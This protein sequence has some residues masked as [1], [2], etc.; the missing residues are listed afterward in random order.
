MHQTYALMQGGRIYTLVPI[1]RRDDPLFKC[2][3]R[4]WGFMDGQ[5]ISCFKTKKDF[6]TF[7]QAEPNDFPNGP[8]AAA[9]MNAICRSEWEGRQELKTMRELK[10]TR[11]AAK[12]A[13]RRGEGGA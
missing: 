1:N 5:R 9:T 11:D 8:H 7:V 12:K 13:N 3:F 6:E 4:W 2:G 10:E